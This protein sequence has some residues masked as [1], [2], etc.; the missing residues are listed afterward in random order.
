MM[1]RGNKNGSTGKR[2]RN[3]NS[4]NTSL[5]DFRD[6]V[7][8]G[9]TISISDVA[10]MLLASHDK[11]Q[12]EIRNKC[13]ELL[14]SHNDIDTKLQK[15][16]TKITDQDKRIRALELKEL[17][18]NLIL[19]GI[20]LHDDV[21]DQAEENRHQTRQQVEQMLQ[22]IGLKKITIIRT[23]RFKNNKTGI[24]PYI[25]VVLADKFEKRAIFKAMKETRPKMITIDHEYPKSMKEELAD[26]RK[27]AHKIR[28]DSGFTTKTRVEV[29]N[30]I[31][32]IM[33]KTAAEDRYTQL[34]Q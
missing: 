9:N 29:R 21:K 17:E 33:Q 18:C 19:K 28:V 8:Q 25:Q 5:N 4:E 30:L 7:N 26:A 31:P 24:P 23:K 14:D 16:E 6:K 15:A 1:T 27:K 20:P 3:D 10:A 12:E 32:V 2:S 11:I 34:S 13:N 22:E